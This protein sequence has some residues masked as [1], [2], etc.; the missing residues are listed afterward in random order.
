VND[1]LDLL[2]RIGIDVAEAG[3][4]ALF[5]S[6]PDTIGLDDMEISVGTTIW[7]FGGYNLWK[8]RCKPPTICYHNYITVKH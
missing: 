4:P 8:H 5:D 2:L 7:L 1:L 6:R 3:N